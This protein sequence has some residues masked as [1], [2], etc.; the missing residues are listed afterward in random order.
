MAE[1]FGELL[2]R[3]REGRPGL[4]KGNR[5]GPG[6]ACLSQNELARRAEVHPSYINRLERGLSTDP[7]SDVTLPRRGLVESLATAL[8]CDE[9]DTARLLI[10]AGFWPWPDLSEHEIGRV[11]RAVYDATDLDWRRKG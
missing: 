11:L 2:R 7:R 8:E 4:V 1:T 3:F 10:A 5:Y 9:H 6:M